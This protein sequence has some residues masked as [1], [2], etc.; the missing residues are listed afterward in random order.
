[1]ANTVSISLRRPDINAKGSL[2]GQ[3]PVR[4]LRYSLP[5]SPSPVSPPQ[6]S[7][8]LALRRSLNDYTYA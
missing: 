4:P 8:Y 5:Q 1:M 7:R 3:H 6:L 2:V